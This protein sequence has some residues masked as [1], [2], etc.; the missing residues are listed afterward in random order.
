VLAATRTLPEILLAEKARGGLAEIDFCASMMHISL[1]FKHDVKFT[2]LINMRLERTFIA[3]FKPAP[4]LW[5][6]V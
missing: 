4:S 6:A 5:I 1:I 3:Q 2:K